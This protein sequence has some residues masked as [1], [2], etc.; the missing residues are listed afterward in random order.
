M[1]L[2]SESQELMNRLINHYDFS[3]DKK[4]PI[5]QKQLDNTLHIFHNNLMMADK[6]SS[7]KKTISKVKKNIFII[8][9]ELITVTIIC[10][11]F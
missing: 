1:N 9:L 3:K 4:T 8:K 2:S 6:W 11:G 7:A 5:E 10:I